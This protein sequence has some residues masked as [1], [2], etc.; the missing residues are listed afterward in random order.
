MT[1]E[2][3]AIEELA[4]RGF[5]PKVGTD[6][7]EQLKRH[8]AYVQESGARLGVPQEQLLAHDA[9]SWSNEEFIGYALHFC[10]GGS[11]MRFSGAWLHHIHANF[12]HWQHW[13]FADGFTIPGSGIVDGAIPMPECYALEMVADWL[14]ASRANTGSWDITDWLGKNWS[15]IK[16]HPATRI[17]VADVLS[18]Q[19]YA[20]CFSGQMME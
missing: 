14:G 15:K 17:Y 20:D 8:I 10:G 13:L 16:L 5:N 19:G 1:I 2:S 3:S 12:H 18:E 11:P 4:R 7:A 6:Y 9:S